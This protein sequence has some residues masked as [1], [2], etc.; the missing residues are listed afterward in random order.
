MELYLQGVGVMGAGLE[1]WVQARSV[2]AGLSDPVPAAMP[3]P[4]PD[5]L[6]MNERRRCPA[7]AR[8]ALAVAHEALDASGLGSAELASV[9]ASSDGDGALVHALLESLTG[10]ERQ[11]SPTLFHNSVHNAAAGYFGIATR[12]RRPAT[13]IC[14]YDQLCAAALI[15]SATQVAIERQAVLLVAYDLPMPPPLFY[16]RPIRTGFAVA[17]VLVPERSPRSLAHWRLQLIPRQTASA[18]PLRLSSTLQDNPTGRALPL[19]TLVALRQSGTVRLD[20]GGMTLSIA[21]VPCDDSP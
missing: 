18:S 14:A 5:L 2:L 10:P 20:Y 8:W 15:E 16:V 11:P 1:G 19:L 9:F 13:A 6:P 4:N 3:E 12:S 21:S 7:T 17:L